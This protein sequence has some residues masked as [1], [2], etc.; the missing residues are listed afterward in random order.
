M[1]T[2]RFNKINFLVLYNV[3]FCRFIEKKL[4]FVEEVFML[5]STQ[6]RQTIRD[7]I[8]VISM[9]KFVLKN[10]ILAGVKYRPTDIK[11]EECYILTVFLNKNFFRLLMR[12]YFLCHIMVFMFLLCDYTISLNRINEIV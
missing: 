3:K 4:L 5:L 11:A 1:S 6:Q 10:I 7:C 12:K 8:N 2:Y 9:L